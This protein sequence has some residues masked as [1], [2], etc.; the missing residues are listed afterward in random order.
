MNAAS[1]GCRLGGGGGL[2]KLSEGDRCK[3][4]FLILGAA[5]RRFQNQPHAFIISL[6]FLSRS[7]EDRARLSLF[8]SF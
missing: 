3:Q 5:I 6:D 1:E 2:A 7:E 8:H 4:C